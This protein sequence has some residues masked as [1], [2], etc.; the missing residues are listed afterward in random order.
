M[1]AEPQKTAEPERAAAGP[2]RAEVPEAPRAGGVAAALLGMQRAVGNAAVQRMI[3]QRAPA[4]G[5]EGGE[6][7]SEV[8]AEIQG[9]RGGGQGLDAALRGRMEGAFGSD[10]GGVRVHTGARADALT[11]QLGARAFTTGK[12]IFFRAGE[13][14]PATRG[15]RELLAHELTHVV[16]QAGAP[17]QRKLTVGPVG[18]AHEDAADRAARAVVEGESAGPVAAGAEPGR[19]QRHEAPIHQTIDR[20]ATGGRGAPPWA[21]PDED[22]LTSEEA[23]AMYFGNWMRDI[24]QVF[25]PLAR[26]ILGDDLIFSTVSY[27]AAEK[28][29]RF[30]TPDEF[31]YYI[32]AEHLD[33]PAGLTNVDDIYAGPP[34]I[35]GQPTTSSR[36]DRLDTLQESVEPSGTVGAGPEEEKKARIFDVDRAGVIAYLRR[37]SFHVERRLELAAM[38]GRTPEG[39][40]HFGAATHAIEDLFAHSNWI[41]MAVN[42][43]LEDPLLLPQ[44]QGAD[45]KAFTFAREVELARPG[46]ASKRRPVLM[47]GSF[48]STDTQI[49][50]GSEAAGTLEKPIGEPKSDAERR[51]HKQLVSALLRDFDRKRADRGPLRD[52]I[53]GKMRDLGL[54]EERI[55]LSRK[56]KLQALYDI[57]PLLPMDWLNERETVRDYR[58]FQ[59]RL[60]EDEVLKPAAQLTKGFGVQGRMA[61]TSLIQVYRDAKEVAAG[62]LGFVD[63]AKVKLKMS[64]GAVAGES[65]GAARARAL[66]DIT[67]EAKRHVAVLDQTP[68]A[69]I[70]GPT[71][72]QISKDH[73]NSPFFGLAYAVAVRAVER[74]WKGMSAVWSEQAR[75]HPFQFMPGVWPNPA[76]RGGAA[77]A[78]YHSG[79]DRRAGL[80]AD[81]VERGKRILKE[82]GDG[83]PYD[84]EK[85]RGVSAGYLREVAELLGGR[86][87]GP[88]ESGEEILAD[89]AYALNAEIFLADTHAKRVRVHG[90]ILDFQAKVAKAGLPMAARE[91]IDKLLEVALRDTRV[92]FT[93]EQRS[94]VK[95]GKW[96]GPRPEKSPTELNVVDVKWPS[97]EQDPWGRDR[98]PARVALLAEARR[99]F[100]HP[101]EDTSWWKDVVV[102]YVVKHGDRLATD[103]RARNAGYGVLFHPGEK[104]EHDDH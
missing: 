71:H 61:D 63:D 7:P 15:G 52:L 98:S 43:V 17:V 13:F 62:N 102:D 6:V 68:E 41:E 55:A 104:R 66:H 70:A 69:V 42:R 78:L 59:N 2:E 90:R 44:L 36:P 56:M 40:M 83:A 85:M 86:R 101:Y 39:L 14:A 37:S 33:S 77:H 60:V 28:F 11:H 8:E 81:S 26:S 21:L 88:R 72:S 67:E 3:A 64:A 96:D 27:L 31:G 99:I 74:I 5:P 35:T 50:L 73:P 24:N 89:E 103:I 79:R 87:G 29:G 25:V 80:A 18:D 19:V 54:P 76:E 12:D 1:K 38:A 75:A 23:S 51:A 22:R 34:R 32:P 95:E 58:A 100:N 4:V 49:S 20:L 53:E 97:L 92:S 94:V 10:F 82:G 48:T 65:P 47:T 9:A 91:M 16:Q 30:M 57:T 45:R 93:S 84:L 46:E